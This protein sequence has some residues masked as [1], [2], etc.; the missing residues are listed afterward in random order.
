MARLRWG[1]DTP[2][3]NVEARLRLVDAAE[4]CFRRFG[5]AKTTV[6]DIAETAQVSRAT[7]YRY[8][9]GRD[10]VLL[11]VLLR[12]A[13]AFLDRLGQRL[14]R[15]VD[16]ADAIVSG[17]LYTVKSVRKDESLALLFAPEAAG[18]TSSV[19]GASEAL[20]EISID[21]LRP[22]LESAQA[23]GRL[24]PGI[25][26]DDAAEWLLRTILSLLT[27]EGPRK[28]SDARMKGLVTHFVLPALVTPT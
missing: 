2:G 10:E 4:V 12:H 1:A 25:E 5:V 18:L 22:M 8:F 24:R 28:P 9:K 7:V 17:I 23:N 20:F 16:V 14:A 15:E 11:A 13:Q 19:A 6:E 3:T 27:V 26:I 21:F